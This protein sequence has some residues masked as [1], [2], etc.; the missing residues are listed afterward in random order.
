M[1]KILIIAE[2]DGAKLNNS[3]AKA[4][5]CAKEIGGDI[6]VAVFAKVA[7]EVAEAAAKLQGVGKVLSVER[8]ENENPLAAVLAP[9]IAELA[10]EYSHLLAPSTTF[11]KDIMPRVAAMLDSPQVSDVMQVIDPR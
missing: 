10:K 11:G 2:H 4:L 5:S 3:T 1:T 8:A 9:Q 7:A 6:D